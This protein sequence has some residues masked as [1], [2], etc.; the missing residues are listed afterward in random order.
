MFKNFRFRWTWKNNVSLRWSCDNKNTLINKCKISFFD[1]KTPFI[2]PFR[3]TLIQFWTTRTIYRVKFTLQ[4]NWLMTE[5]SHGHPGKLLIQSIR[6]STLLK[7]RHGGNLFEQ[8]VT[9]SDTLWRLTHDDVT[10][11]TTRVMRIKHHADS[12][13]VIAPELVFWN[14]FGAKD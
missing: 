13:H 6:A 1:K 3:R 10:Q 7:S 2:R 9:F 8:L 12:R 4:S 11:M 14:F 5:M